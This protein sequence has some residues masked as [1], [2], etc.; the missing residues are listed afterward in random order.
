MKMNNKTETTQKWHQQILSAVSLSVLLLAGLL[1]T[2]QAQS[3]N[4]PILFTSQRVDGQN[5][6]F[7]MNVN[8]IN[9]TQVGVPESRGTFARYSP[10]GQKIAYART[11]ADASSPVGIRR[12]IFVM[13]ANG[14][15]QVNISNDLAHHHSRPA[16]SPDGSKIAFMRFDLD[17][18]FGGDIW[19]MNADGSNQHVVYT[20]PGGLGALYPFFSPDGRIGFNSDASG[21]YEVYVINAD[22][23][24]LRQLTDNIDAQSAANDW[25]PD[26]TKIVFTRERYRAG[27][28]GV[29]GNSNIFVMNADGTNVIR[30]TSHGNPDYSPIYS[31]DGSEIVFARANGYIHN[32]DICT[33]NADGSNVV[34]LSNESSFN[35][36]TDWGQ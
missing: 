28:N 25:S 10:N 29:R 18:G 13:N 12:Q 23:S 9:P 35:L 26:G 24:N 16:W 4:L 15:N 30:L 17:H 36:P 6:I 7:G 19:I 1:A 22:G 5:R 32:V 34:R 20:S 27:S 3:G 14:T 33:M 21:H 31:P 2:A 8:G 11:D